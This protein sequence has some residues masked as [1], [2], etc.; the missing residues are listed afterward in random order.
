MKLQRKIKKKAK[1]SIKVKLKYCECLFNLEDVYSCIIEKVEN[2]FDNTQDDS[3]KILR[4][5]F[6]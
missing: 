1:D 3:L 2:S 6:I 5:N 4:L